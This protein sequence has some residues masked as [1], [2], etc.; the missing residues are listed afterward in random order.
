MNIIEPLNIVLGFIIFC[1]FIMLSLILSFAIYDIIQQNKKHKALKFIKDT[2]V[3]I[4][5]SIG[6]VK[7]MNEHHI[8]FIALC[9]RIELN[10]SKILGKK[11]SKL[12]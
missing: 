3:W 9:Y 6:Y 8:Y 1:V 7:F 4:T 5:P 10:F 12:G 2:E 11:P